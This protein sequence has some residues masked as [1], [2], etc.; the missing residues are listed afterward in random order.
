MPE[1]RLT[2]RAKDDL[3]A[4]P[5][6]IQEAVIE[7]LTTIG[8]DPT[9]AGKPLVGRLRGLW[10]ARVGNYRVLYTLDESAGATRVIVRAIR[11]RAVAY[12]TRR[13]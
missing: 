7:A 5:R 13:D 2:A 3:G 11:H 1:P 6:T 10:S 9:T 8:F 12:Q 4:L